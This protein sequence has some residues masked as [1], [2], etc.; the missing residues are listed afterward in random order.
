MDIYNVSEESLD[1]CGFITGGDARVIPLVFQLGDTARDLT[2]A[3]IVSYIPAEDGSTI[4]VPAIDHALTTAAQGKASITLSAA[5]TARMKRT[6]KV[7]FMAKV[8]IAA[9]VTAYWGEFSEVRE[10]IK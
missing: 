8:T 4:V 5:V 3:S 9:V 10:P 1:D 7:P 6:A 2:G